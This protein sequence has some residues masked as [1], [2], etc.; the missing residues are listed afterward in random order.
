MMGIYS[1]APL[2]GVMEDRSETEDDINLKQLRFFVKVVETGNITRASELLNLAQTALGQQIRQLEDSLG[3][4]LLVRHSRGISLTEPGEVLY[5]RALAILQAV[6]EA[7]RDVIVSGGDRK[8]VIR[9]GVTPSLLGLIGSELLELA[10]E[11]LPQITLRLVEELSFILIDSLQRGELDLAIASEIDTKQG[12]TGMALIE[13][14]LL[15]VTGADADIPAGPIAFHEVLNSDLALVSDRD[16]VWKILHEA[17]DRLSMRVNVAFKVQS[18]PAI[19][20]LVARGAA[21][22]VMP[23]GVVADEIEQGTIIARPIVQPHIRRTLFLSQMAGRAPFVHEQ[24]M[25]RFLDG[26]V[27][28]LVARMQSHGTL[29]DRG[30]VR[31]LEPQRTKTGA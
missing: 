26:I 1:D 24:E 29:I 15:F 6:N 7:R 10:R 21:T 20:I 18:M 3:V 14:E 4:Q 9:L 22:S 16:V 12:L 17:A 8:E 23:F 2:S 31:G 11:E 19:K 5:P 25:M 13:E 28:R 30:L 27:R